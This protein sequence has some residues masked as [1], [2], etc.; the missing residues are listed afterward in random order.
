MGSAGRRSISARRVS[1]LTPW[2]ISMAQEPPGCARSTACWRDT[3]ASLMTMSLVWLRPML[4]MSGR[5]R[6]GLSAKESASPRPTPPAG[7][8]RGSTCTVSCAEAGAVH[9]PGSQISQWYG[10]LS[11]NLSP[12]ATAC[13]FSR[14]R[15][16][17]GTIGLHHSVIRQR[18]MNEP[19]K[20][21]RYPRQTFFI[22]GNEAAERFSFYGMTS[23]LFIYMS[24]DL[25]FGD[26]VA[27][28]RYHFF[29]AAVYYMPLLGGFLADRFFGRYRI[30]LWVSFLYLA[31]HATLAVW[32][33]PWG[34]LAGCALIALGAGGIKPCVSAFVGDQFTKDQKSLL[35]RAY[36]WFYFAINVGAL[37][38]QPLIP[39]LKD[40]SE[41][42]KAG[43]ASLTRHQA[44]Q[45]AFGVPGL[46]MALALIIYVAGRNLYVKAPP[47][48]RN[49]NGF[50]RVLFG[51]GF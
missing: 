25:G 30:I 9:V 51:S 35:E 48:G 5:P 1:D 23:I 44:T 42:D 19:A 40:L 12:M 6:L 46:A 10:Y 16:Y 18:V 45:L 50:L 17:D 37:I 8:C 38:G 36:G 11:P 20:P 32:D 3:V 34:L 21:G 43:H 22:V 29:T 27:T 13:T 28:A 2:P 41:L 7:V 49:P 14:E 47:T 4:R 24:K 31:G 33:G 39:F 26:G 15:R